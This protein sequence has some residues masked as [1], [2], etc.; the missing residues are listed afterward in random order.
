[1]NYKLG[2]IIMVLLISLSSTANA[3]VWNSNSS[4]VNGL[5]DVG[6]R[7]TPTIYDD[8]G[9]WKLINGQS[10][11]GFDW[12]DTSWNSNSSIVN[13]LP[14][15]VTA[16]TIFND[17]GN[18]KLIGGTWDGYV[19]G[20]DW[21][22]TEWV[23]NSSI[24]NG[25][26]SSDDGSY[27]YQSDPEVFFMDN[28]FNIIIGYYRGYVVGFDWDGASWNSNSSIVS[29]LPTSPV[30]DGLDYHCTVFN[31]SG[32][33]KLI[34]SK[35]GGTFDGYQWSGSTWNSNSSIVNGLPDVGARVDLSIFDD[36]GIWKLI[37]G[38]NN[39][40]FNGFHW[41]ENPPTIPTSFTN[42]GN[43]LIDHTPTITWTEGTDVDG[44]TLTTYVYVGTTSTPTTIEGSTAGE[45]L[46][47]GTNTTLTDGNTYYYRL[48]SYDGHFYSDYT[49]ADEFKM[50]NAPTIPTISS[51]TNNSY[52]TSQPITIQANST[53]A[54]GDSLTYYFY[55][56]TVDGSTLLGTS[57]NGTY[58][59]HQA[60]S[61]D[62]ILKVRA[63]DGYEYSEY[64]NLVYFHSLIPPLLTTNLVTNGDFEDWSSGPS[65]APD[66]WVLFGAGGAVERESTLIK[67]GEYSA[68]ITY[69]TAT[70]YIKYIIPN[71]ISLRGRII[72]LGCWV[73]A[74][75]ASRGRIQISDNINYQ[76]SNYHSGSGDWEWISTSFTVGAAATAVHAKMMVYNADSVYYDGA[77][78]VEG[79]YEGAYPYVSEPLN[80]SV[81]TFD[82]PPLLHD[83]TFVWQDSDA[84]G[85]KYQIATDENFNLISEEG[86][87]STYTTDVSLTANDYFWRLF[88]YDPI[89]DTYSDSSDVW[90]FTINETTISDGTAIDGVVYEITNAGSI[91]VEG[92]LVNI[93]NTT[94]SDSM[95]VGQ[96]GYYYFDGVDNS[97]YSLRATKTGYTDSAIELVTATSD[98][99]TTR[100]ILLQSTSGAGQQYVDHYVKFIVKSWYGTLYSDVT[101]NVYLGDAIIPQHT[102]DTGT[103]GAVV[104][105]LNE[106]Q[107]YR[108]TF[109]D[110]AQNIDEEKILYPK[111]SEYSIIVFG[112]NLIPDE[113]ASDDIL[114]TVQGININSTHGFINVSFTDT[115]GTTSLAELWIKN[116][117]NQSTLYHFNTTDS[118]K[119][120]SQVVD[121]GNASYLI[122]FKIDNT[123]LTDTLTITR[124]I[125]FDNDI[126]I[127]LG[128][129]NN[130]SYIL[131]AVIIISI[132]ALLSTKLNSEIMA[133]ITVLTGWLMVFFGWLTAGMTIEEKITV[134]LMLLL[135]TL[136]AFATMAKK[137]EK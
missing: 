5:P 51:P 64:S 63:H 45:T 47:L 135:A 11:F 66:G 120:W 28:K 95:L 24:V 32:T 84:D 30:Q 85:Y 103:D 34:S 123:I 101:V 8:N 46:D 13:G 48:R 134:G 53:D 107:E 129:E 97:T 100:N 52:Y 98:A 91:A 104:F 121:G 78:L 26:P 4:V 9:I 116:K 31:D 115:S 3:E 133:V 14:D 102:D 110:A 40:N 89:T 72:T 39:G 106:N 113:P 55:G 117:N 12:N 73:K 25:L 75:S 68:K 136:V 79:A 65:A 126:N 15:V 56:D 108:I 18:R 42:L 76:F 57:T 132:P 35:Y 17:N 43:N 41:N 87:L 122:V 71:P 83:I 111:E 23:S 1:M 125:Y 82:F 70:T 49:I 105:E 27:P 124:T 59:W 29:G 62:Y 69:G 44:D 6:F 86:S 21:N 131:I 61:G 118:T 38:N 128:L 20:F 16:T 2:F 137:G 36:N 109:I 60:L 22:N 50:N 10:N 96:N 119:E 114:Y 93:W 58:V 99:T 80:N 127:N 19:V 92:A 54:D 67:V 7:A 81:H 90:Q 88:A 33:W 74:S 94:W 37:S 77:I 130:W 112:A